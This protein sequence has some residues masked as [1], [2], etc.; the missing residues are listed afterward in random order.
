MDATSQ[1]SNSSLHARTNTA[2][3]TILAW[4]G[5]LLLSRLPQILLG[6]TGLIDPAGWQTWW[7]I[8][9][10]IGLIALTF[11]WPAV[12][13]LRG[14]FLVLTLIYVVALLQGWISQTGLWKGWFGSE[15][16]WPMTFWGDRLLLIFLGLCLVVALALKGEKRRD[17]FLTFGKINAP[18]FG[19]HWRG[20]QI[21]LPWT[22]AGPVFAIGLSLLTGGAILAFSPVSGV[23]ASRLLSVLPAVLALALIN[24]FGEELAYRAAPLSQLWRVVGSRQAVWL[25]AVWFGLGHYYGGVPSGIM[26]AVFLSLVALLMGKAMLDTKGLAMPVFIHVWGDVIVYLVIGLAAV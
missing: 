12:K 5:M 25:T 14:F 24:A 13:A 26:G 17:Y 18:A 6:E 16:P 7:W 15:T 23:S 20:R 11:F 21:S 2:P 8:A 3:I 1:L 10:G 22:I 19:W 9:A 4:L